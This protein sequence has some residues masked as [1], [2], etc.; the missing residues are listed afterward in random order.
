MSRVSHGM[1]RQP[2]DPRTP[3]S[4][5][6]A[7][8]TMTEWSPLPNGSTAFYSYCAKCWYEPGPNAPSPAERTDVDACSCER[9][10]DYLCL[11][12]E[13]IAEDQDIGF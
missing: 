7:P 8:A 1:R 11:R 6:D 3:C 9:G 12:C 2:N 4:R 13:R 5:C 10:S